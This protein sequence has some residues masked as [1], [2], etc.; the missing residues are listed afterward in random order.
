VGKG[1]VG[2][3]SHDNKANVI[4]WCARPAQTGHDGTLRH[5]RMAVC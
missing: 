4:V 5:P 1:H 2:A 3:K